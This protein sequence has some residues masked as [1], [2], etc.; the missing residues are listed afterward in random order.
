VIGSVRAMF[1]REDR[2]K[3]QL[4]VNDVV[5]DV[6]A[7][8]NGEIRKQRISVRAE[9][10]PDLP[11]VVADRTQLQQVFMNLIMN[12][13]EAME[14]VAP[15]ERLLVVKSQT[16]DQGTVMMTVED[17]GVGIDGG[18]KERIFDALFTTKTNGMGMGLPIC[19]SI[20]EAHGGR[21]WAS[22]RVPHGSVFHVVLPSGE[23]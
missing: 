14:R 20:V 9:L 23:R 2:P 4:A 3:A 5:E 10:Q 15:R 1:K 13:I 11:D 17:S 16:H 21:L 7:L 22:P 8:V 18:E 6:L 19:R 12:A